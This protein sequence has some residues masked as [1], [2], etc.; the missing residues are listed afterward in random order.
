MQRSE[1]GRK[2]VNYSRETVLDIVGFFIILLYYELLMYYQLH[3]SFQGFSLWNVAFLIP[4]AFL[5][6]AFTGWS[7]RSSRIN[8]LIKTLL[9]F[10]VSLFY[11]VDLIYF[12]TFGSLLSASMLSYGTDAVNNFWWSLSS[13]LAENALSIFLMEIP[14]FILLGASF[15]QKQSA[16]R[17]SIIERVALSVVSILL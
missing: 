16:K 4:V 17:K 10:L 14:T 1:T 11:I 8:G 6:G 2:I 12:K 13:T 15:S 5:L 9:V 3:S 7:E